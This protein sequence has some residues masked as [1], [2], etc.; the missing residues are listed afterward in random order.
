VPVDLETAVALARSTR[1][2]VL[3]TVRANGRPQLSNVWHHVGDDGRVRVSITADRAKYANLRRDPWAALHVTRSDFNAYVVVECDVALSPI[4]AAPDDGTVDDLVTHY[5][6]IVG[7][8]D[9]WDAFRRAQ[10]DQR[11]VLV[12]LTPQRAYGRPA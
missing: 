11:R 6:T 1:E 4:A 3:V 12:A 7:E 5:R 9:D 2:S 8:H 10:V